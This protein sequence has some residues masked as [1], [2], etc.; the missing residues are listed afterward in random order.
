[1]DLEYVPTPVAPLA[2]ERMLGK[3]ESKLWKKLKNILQH[4]LASAPNYVVYNPKRRGYF[5]GNDNTIQVFSLKTQQVAK[6]WGKDDSI[7]KCLRVRRDGQLGVYSTLTGEVKVVSFTHKS[8]L[9]SFKLSNQP[10]YAL[11]LL[12]KRPLIAVGGDNGAFILRD[13]AAE[14]TL[15][16]EPLL[17][18]DFLRKC[19]FFDEFGQKIL[20]GGQDRKVCL[21][22]VRA[23]D[24]TVAKLDLDKELSDIVCI[25][26]TKFLTLSGRE[27]KLW[28]VARLNAPIFTSSVAGKSLSAGKWVGN[29]LFISSFD[30]SLRIA[31][32]ESNR[33]EIVNQKSFKAPISAFDLGMNQDGD[34]KS[35]G[36]ASV[37]GSFRVYSRDK[38]D[39]ASAK[40]P[41]LADNMTPEE[42]R[43]LRILS[44]GVGPKEMN[45]FQY[46]D[47]GIWGSAEGFGVKIAHQKVPKASAYDKQL[48]KFQFDKALI[49]ALRTGDSAVIVAVI[50]E[51]FIR[52]VWKQTVKGLDEPSLAALAD[53]LLKKVDSWNCQGLITAALDGFL[54]AVSGTVVTNPIL[55]RFL[56]QL[57]D[58]I[59][60]EIQNSERCALIHS[61]ISDP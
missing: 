41:D 34:I 2:R 1:M 39:P 33:M 3:A 26:D 51:L 60:A 53:F 29:K 5:F 13:F 15:L 30:G 20:T 56:N 7:V 55:D 54:E 40:E 28:D 11:D 17:H 14:M 61:Y 31:T 50:E 42:R 44:V 21:I 27:V 19:I 43:L 25:S 9:K 10:I 46:F 35:V 8:M 45:V 59:E 57:A 36:I 38:N 58:K 12:E 22:D 18:S 16:K 6:A 23:N 48:R 4:K 32:V 37:D 52:S 49:A 47:R 24:H